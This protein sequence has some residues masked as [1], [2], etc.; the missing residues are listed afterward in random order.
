[1]HEFAHI[2]FLDSRPY[3]LGRVIDTTQLDTQV[4]RTRLR[5]ELT[6]C[7]PVTDA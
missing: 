1:M 4:W 7:M 5:D 3:L 6:V 2:L